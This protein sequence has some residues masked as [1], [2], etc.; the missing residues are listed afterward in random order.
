MG[1]N[2]PKEEFHWNKQVSKMNYYI[3]TEVYNYLKQVSLYLNGD[4]N[5]FKR[6]SKEIETKEYETPG[7]FKNI[8]EYNTTI[9]FP[10]PTIMPDYN[11]HSESRSI[12]EP[13]EFKLTVPMTT[14]LFS[15][16][17]LLGYLLGNSNNCLKT[18]ENLHF[19][20]K[21]KLLSLNENEV[22]IL[23]SLYRNGLAHVYFPKSG[24]GISYHSLNPVDQLFIRNSNTHILNVN[25]LIDKVQSLFQYVMT[26][27][28]LFQRMESRYLQ[29]KS[30]Y[31]TR[32]REVLD[33]FNNI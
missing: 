15:V 6:I 26:N 5:T 2:C 19:F 17:D 27:E 28:L 9:Q 8:T 12:P 24:L 1:V 16:A 32:N 18:N 13:T 33:L 29:M 21:H 11:S 23:I 31:E 30:F 4:L 3:N 10:T 7:E 20:F 14:S 22:K 25:V